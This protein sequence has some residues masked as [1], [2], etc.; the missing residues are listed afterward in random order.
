MPL[1]TYHS[2]PPPGEPTID[3]A[4]RL[5][6]DAWDGCHVQIHNLRREYDAAVQVHERRDGPDPS[7]LRLRLRSMQTNCDQLFFAML[8]AAETRTRERYI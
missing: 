4:V 2:Q 6:F 1:S 8:K 5:A 7:D 3:D